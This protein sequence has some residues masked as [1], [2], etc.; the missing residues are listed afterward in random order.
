MSR[1]QPGWVGGAPQAQGEQQA[2]PSLSI[3]MIVG[4]VLIAAVWAAGAVWSFEEQSDFAHRLHFHVPWLLPLAADGLPVALGAIALNAALDGRGS[5]GARAAT[6]LAVGAS[7]ASNGLNAWNRTKTGVAPQVHHDLT[8]VIVACAVP[9]LAGIAFERLLVELRKAVLSARRELPP[10]RDKGAPAPALRLIR[11][12]LDPVHEIPSWRRTVLAVTDPAIDAA[13]RRELVRLVSQIRTEQAAQRMAGPDSAVLPPAP[14]S[15]T[16]DTAGGERFEAPRLEAAGVPLPETVPLPDPAA[17]PAGKRH[18]QTALRPDPAALPAGALSET[19][20][21]PGSG[22]G[23]RF[24]VAPA[25]D[26]GRRPARARRAPSNAETTETAVDAE[27]VAAAARAD[28]EA[29]ERTGRPL[30]YRAAPGVLGT[31]YSTA[32]E[33]L[34]AARAAAAQAA[35]AAR[36]AAALAAHAETAAQPDRAGAPD[37]AVDASTDGPVHAG[38]GE[39][40]HAAAEATGST[41]AQGHAADSAADGV[42]VGARS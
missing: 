20:V 42:L 23:E 11:V 38:P 12:L 30:S 32:R 28:R 33:A 8:T 22:D 15:D 21:R 41:A 37:A 10:P 5:A 39:R 7:V 6:M 1:E 13:T 26:A 35:D 36:P 34:D 2:G 14:R 24:A 29:R 16:A 18:G 40:D 17:L 4:L 3:P 31:R 19:A 9:T 25:P 27:L